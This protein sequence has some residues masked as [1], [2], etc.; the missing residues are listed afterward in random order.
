M[1][2]WYANVFTILFLLLV[3]ICLRSTIV[4]SFYS[5]HFD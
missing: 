2:Y 1:K 3:K 5:P 4:F